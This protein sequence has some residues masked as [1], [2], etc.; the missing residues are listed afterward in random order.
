MPPAGGLA[1]T[2]KPE[3]A[4][5]LRTH[6]RYCVCLRL[7]FPLP[8]PIRVQAV[9]RGEPPTP[10]TRTTASRRH[11]RRG[12]GPSAARGTATIIPSQQVVPGTDVW[13]S[14]GGNAKKAGGRL[15]H[16]AR[17]AG[18]VGR[19]GAA[20]GGGRDSRLDPGHEAL[21]GVP[22]GRDLRVVRR[23]AAVP[24]P[25]HHEEAEP[26]PGVGAHGGLDLSQ[27][28]LRP[29]LRVVRVRPRLKDDH[30]AAGGAEGTPVKLGV[31]S[32]SEIQ[33]GGGQKSDCPP[34]VF[35]GSRCKYNGSSS[36]ANQGKWGLLFVYVCVCLQVGRHGVNVTTDAGVEGV[37]VGGPVEGGGV[38][39]QVVEDHV[40]Q[41]G[42]REGSR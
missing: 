12:T 1:W 3:A 42:H 18:A 39:S 11:R 22:V 41:N 8:A 20:Q 27:V 40:L 25:R 14:E 24:A 2:T 4:G 5:L 15:A 38:V 16:L 7:P 10:H 21:D 19:V 23:R 13:R 30:L 35:F 36:W 17:A 28:F 31:S 37:D 29:R 6:K 33:G 26:G 34:G 9:R 32:F